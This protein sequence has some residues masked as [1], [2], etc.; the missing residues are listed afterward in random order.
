MVHAFMLVVIMGTGEFRK[1]LPNPMIFRDINVCLYYAKRLPRQYGNYSYSS[2]V[3]AKDRITTYCKPV[4]VQSNTLLY[5][6]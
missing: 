2:L 4:Q 5:D 1:E 6:H 3:D